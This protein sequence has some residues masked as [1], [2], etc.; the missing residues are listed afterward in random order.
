M[1]EDGG[2][3]RKKGSEIRLSCAFESNLGS[4]NSE[5]LPYRPSRSHWCV[6]EAS[7][8]KRLRRNK[9]EEDHSAET[10]KSDTLPDI[11]VGSEVAHNAS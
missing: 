11:S 6:P 4:L 5:S 2:V 10:L 8:K 1:S 3:V 9:A 7:V